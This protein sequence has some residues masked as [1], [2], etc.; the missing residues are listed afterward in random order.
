LADRTV[1]HIYNVREALEAITLE[2]ADGMTIDVPLSDE[3]LNV[4][5]TDSD[6]ADAANLAEWYPLDA[7]ATDNFDQCC[8]IR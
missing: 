7:A 5:P 3:G 8:A 6:M 1:N 4:D 2:A